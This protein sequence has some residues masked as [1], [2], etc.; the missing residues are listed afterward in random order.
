MSRKHIE[1]A[2]KVKTKLYICFTGDL[3]KL[4]EQVFTIKEAAPYKMRVKFFVQKGELVSGL[5]YIQKT[6]RKG[7]KGILCMQ[8]A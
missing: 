8:V 7:V 1:K 2:S 3:S 6:Y 4:K 5:K